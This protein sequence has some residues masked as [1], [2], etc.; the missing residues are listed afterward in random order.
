MDGSWGTF[1]WRTQW[2]IPIPPCALGWETPVSPCTLGWADRDCFGPYNI[3]QFTCF[4]CFTRGLLG[5]LLGLWLLGQDPS[6]QW[7]SWLPCLPCPITPCEPVKPHGH[8]ADEF[9]SSCVLEAMKR[10]LANLRHIWQRGYLCLRL[11]TTAYRRNWASMEES[12]ISNQ[13]LKAVHNTR[14]DFPSVSWRMISKTLNKES[15]ST[16]RNWK[17]NVCTFTKYRGALKAIGELKR[18]DCVSIVQSQARIQ[19][20]SHHFK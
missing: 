5:C 20:G 12:M 13:K 9:F 4:S 7:L 11:F 16:Q 18:K 15:Y 1:K 19:S 14:K 6:G 17:W 10:F 2:T 3:Y 8:L